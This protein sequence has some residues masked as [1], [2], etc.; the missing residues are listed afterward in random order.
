M[1]EVTTTSAQLEHYLDYLEAS[2]SELEDSSRRWNELTDDDKNDFLA[3]WP[4]VEGK[5]L[6]LQRLIEREGVPTAYRARYEK[7]QELVKR[8]RPILESLRERP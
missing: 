5:L 2:F 8:D 4:V 6:G 7:L 3:E 1:A